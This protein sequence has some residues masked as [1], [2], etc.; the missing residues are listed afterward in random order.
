M[1]TKIGIAADHAGFLYK[2]QLLEY[3]EKKG[4]SVVDF[5]TNSTDSVDYPDYAHALGKAM[6]KGEIEKG[7]VICGSA[8]GITM[9]VNKHQSVRAAICWNEEIALLAR[10]HNDANVCGIPARFIDYELAESIVQLFLDTKF[11]GGRHQKRVSKIS[12]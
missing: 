4:F 8:N 12:C 1:K 7:I 6:D 5:G 3:F 9:S 11:E 2:K 10:Q